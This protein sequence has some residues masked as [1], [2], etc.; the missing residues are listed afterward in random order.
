MALQ[1]ANKMFAFCIDDDDL[2]NFVIIYCRSLGGA[3]Q[4]TSARR[5]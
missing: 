3:P 5:H 4:N 1:I 2:W